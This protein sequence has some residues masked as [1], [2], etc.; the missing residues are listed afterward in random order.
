MTKTRD[1]NF[2]M[3]ETQHKDHPALR[4]RYHL[5]FS[6]LAL[7]P[8]EYLHSRGNVKPLQKSDLIANRNKHCAKQHTAGQKNLKNDELKHT[9]KHIV[10]FAY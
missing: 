8:Q 10:I 2:K 5:T 3:N 1:R 9:A 7:A 4:P 6:L